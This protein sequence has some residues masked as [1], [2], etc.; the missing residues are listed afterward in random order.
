MIR[1]VILA[2]C[3]CSLAGCANETLTKSGQM[4]PMMLGATAAIAAP[5]TAATSPAPTASPNLEISRKSLASK[6]LT[7]RAL[8]QVTGMTVDPARFSELD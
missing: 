5:Q 8:E 7:G 1:A 6:V 4:S 2:G 3:A